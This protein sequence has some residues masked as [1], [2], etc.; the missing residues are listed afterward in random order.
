MLCIKTNIT[1]CTDCRYLNTIKATFKG[2]KWKPRPW[3]PE[4]RSGPWF[5]LHLW[6]TLGLEPRQKKWN[7]LLIMSTQWIITLSAFM[8]GTFWPLP[9][10]TQARRE[11]NPRPPLV[12]WRDESLERRR[13]TSGN[14]WK[15]GVIPV[16]P[17]DLWRT[18]NWLTLMTTLRHTR[19]VVSALHRSEEQTSRPLQGRRARSPY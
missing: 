10:T 19:D 17:L 12:P 15:G 3:L 14:L 6:M 9:A 13:T 2:K 5:P 4:K 18:R 1:Y 7:L 11:T 8:L 16:G